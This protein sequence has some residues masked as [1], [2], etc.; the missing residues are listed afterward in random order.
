M[1]RKWIDEM[2]EKGMGA[3]YREIHCSYLRSL[4]KISIKSGLLPHEMV[5]P[6][7]L[8]DFSADQVKHIPPFLEADY[9]GLGELLPSL[10]K[11]QRLAM[12]VQAMTGA[13]YSEFYRRDA[14]DF[15]L[16]AGTLSIQHEPEKGKAVKNKH[17]IR[18]IPLP[19]FL[20]EQLRDFDFKWH[21]LD[22]V[23]KKIKRVNPKLSS[24]S[25]RHGMIRVNRDLGGDADAM[26][27][28]TGHRLAGMKTTYGDGYSVER[29]REVATPC[30]E[31]IQTWLFN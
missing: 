19:R 16:D 10:P 5:N 3:R 2:E 30:W 9:R 25:F 23:N 11:P 22:I 15:D 21:T 28:Y 26:E 4:I 27:V 13:R 1:I 6:F 12:L 7:S 17:S 8:V 14:E 29:L 31:Q 20:V 24:H 18:V